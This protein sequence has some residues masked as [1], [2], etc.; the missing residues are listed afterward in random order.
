MYILTDVPLIS[1]VGQVPLCGLIVVDNADIGA[2]SN[3]IHITEV[4]A[5][6]DV[7]EEEEVWVS[8]LV[9]DAESACSM[10]L[11]SSCQCVMNACACVEV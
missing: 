5:V 3:H 9:Q 1:S 8:P 4:H 6:R 10:Q 11:E 2:L 7:G